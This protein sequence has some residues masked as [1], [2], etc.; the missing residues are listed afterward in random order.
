MRK[1]FAVLVA[2]LVMGLVGVVG[3]GITA[4]ASGEIEASA[5]LVPIAT[6]FVPNQPLTKVRGQISIEQT[7]VHGQKALVVDGSARNMDPEDTYVSLL[8]TSPARGPRA[9]QATPQLTFTQMYLGVWKVDQGGRG[10]LHAVKTAAG[11]T[12]PTPSSLQAFVAALGVTPSD[13]SGPGSFVPLT[14]QIR[15]VSIREM[16]AQTSNPALPPVVAERID[17]GALR[18]DHEDDD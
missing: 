12:S 17:C 1:P 2:G 4:F 18:F 10:R 3:S 5:R 16:R 8:Y 14:R 11:N 15:S 9:C 13:L 7:V 6:E